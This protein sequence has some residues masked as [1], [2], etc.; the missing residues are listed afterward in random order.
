MKKWFFLALTVGVLAALLC[1][2][3]K[4]EEGGG[5]SVPPP[6]AVTTA[7]PPTAPPQQT[8]K[9]V[10]VTADDGLNI[11][12]QPSTDGEIL[13]LAENGQKLPLLTEKAD[14]GWYQIIYKGSNAYVS[15][16]YAQLQEVT[17]EEYNRLKEGTSPS[18]AAGGASPSPASTGDVDPQ[19]AGAGTAPDATSEPT[20]SPSPS[21]SA[22]PSGDIEDGE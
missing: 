16:E 20:A 17:L 3:G 7:A 9:A 19:G 15:A 13:G 5:S 10:K 12:S 1:G 6:S 18:S 14:N 2:C 4:K 22:T 21:P 8:A 11:R